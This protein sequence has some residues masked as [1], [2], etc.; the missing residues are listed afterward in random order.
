MEWAQLLKEIV[1][2]CEHICIIGFVPKKHASLLRE[3]ASQHSKHLP[4]IEHVRQKVVG[5]DE[6]ILL[7]E[8]DAECLIIHA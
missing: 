3:M 4:W 7:V 5:D 1:A 2:L 6:I 8:G